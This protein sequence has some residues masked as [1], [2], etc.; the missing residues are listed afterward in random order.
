[1]KCIYST[2]STN[3]TSKYPTTLGS[4]RLKKGYLGDL[5]FK[6]KRNMFGDRPWWCL[7]VSHDSKWSFNEMMIQP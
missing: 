5:E 3:R 6:K 2:S 4:R 7:F 1:M